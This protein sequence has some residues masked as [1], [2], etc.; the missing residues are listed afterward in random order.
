[1]NATFWEPFIW[2][3]RGFFVMQQIVIIEVHYI[4]DA[5]C[6]LFYIQIIMHH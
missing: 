1:M 5:V 2:Y 4:G 6:I 3:H